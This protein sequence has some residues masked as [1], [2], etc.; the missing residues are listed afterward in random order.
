[1]P[2][3]MTRKLDRG[4]DPPGAPLPWPRRCAIGRHAIGRE[5]GSNSVPM[6][7]VRI[8]AAQGDPPTFGHFLSIGLRFTAV[9]SSL[10]A[11]YGLAHTRA[12][13]EEGL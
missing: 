2:R 7:G 1:M 10:G 5:R 3:A 6:G 12:A 11:V 4:L 9:K 8:C 13:H